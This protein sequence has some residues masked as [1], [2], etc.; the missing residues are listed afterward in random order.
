MKSGLLVQHATKSKAHIRMIGIEQGDL[1]VVAH[2]L[3]PERVLH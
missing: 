1:I 3:R 2:L